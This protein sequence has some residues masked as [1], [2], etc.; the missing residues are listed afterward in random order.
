VLKDERPKLLIVTPDFQ[1]P[2]GATLSLDGRV[3][4]LRAAAET[5]T[6]VA[7]N[8]IYADLRYQGEELPSLKKLDE[9]GNVIQL[10]SFSK[11]SFP[12]LRVGWVL[13]PRPVIAQL[14]DAKQWSD[15]HTDQLAQAVLCRFAE[16]GRLEAHR[17]RVVAGGR[18]RLAAALAGCEEHLP[19]GSRFTRPEGG[20]NLWVELPEP[21]DAAEL[22]PRVQDAG[23]SYLPGKYF[24]VARPHTSALR[25]SFAGLG[26]AAIRE[27]LAILG[28]V[29]EKEL[30]RARRVSQYNPAPAM[31]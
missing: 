8:D 5:G 29:F 22:L 19:Q 25:L 26:P 3:A 2:T 11:V 15:L 20:M 30:S 13:G 9:T 21:L 4:L 7:E 31:V 12:G 28:E 17:K 6:V 16:S 18:K 24:A 14:A 23:V 27:G 10:R 1:N